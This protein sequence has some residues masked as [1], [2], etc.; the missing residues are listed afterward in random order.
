[1]REAAKQNEIQRASQSRKRALPLK[2][3]FTKAGVHPFDEVQWRMHKVLVRGS[4]GSKEER[5]LEFPAFWSDNAASIAGSKY[6]RGRIGSP[7]RETS[8]RSMITR[9]VSV[10]SAWGR[11]SGYFS[12]EDESTAKPRP[13]SPARAASIA[14]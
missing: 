7:E 2:R 5:E 11:D 9:V 8:V 4:N 6:F 1:M 13:C 3:R 14:A 10:I 12:T